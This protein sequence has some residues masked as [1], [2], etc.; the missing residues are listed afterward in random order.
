MKSG[1]TVIKGWAS[2]RRSSDR[3]GVA[4]ILVIGLLALMMVMGVSFAVFMRT[5]RMAA[6]NFRNDVVTRQLL[7]VALNQA[8]MAIDASMVTNVYP[9]FDVANSP[10]TASI[11]GATN[12]PAMSW[13]PASVVSASS[14][15]VDPKWIEVSGDGRVGYVVFN[16]SGLLDVNHVGGAARGIG[17]NVNEIQIGELP[18][19]G[20]SAG[21]TSL[22]TGHPYETGQELLVIGTNAGGG[23]ID[24]PQSLVTYSR[25]VSTNTMVDISADA[26]TLATNGPA[27]VAGLIRSGITNTQAPFVFTNLL[28]Y[29]DVGSIP[30]DL[31]SPCTEAVPMINELQ[32]SNILQFSS[33]KV[34]S[35]LAV[36]V[37]WVYPFVKINPA[38][39][40]LRCDV[41][42][43]G[44]GTDIKYVPSGTPVGTGTVFPSGYDGSSADM[45]MKHYFTTFNLTSS[46]TNCAPG[47]KIILKV[48]AGAQVLLGGVPV[49]SVPFPYASAG[50]FTFNTTNTV[51]APIP[52]SG[53]VGS[54]AQGAEVADPRFNW[55]TAS[56][57]VPKQWK[58]YSGGGSLG[59][60][61]SYTKAY[62]AAYPEY[63]ETQLSMHVSDQPLKSVSELSYLVRGALMYDKWST[64]KL[65]EDNRTSLPIDRVL[66]NFSI[67]TNTVYNGKLN[68]NS[69]NVAAITATLKGMPVD[70]YP[71][72]PASITLSSNQAANLATALTSLSGSFD[73]VSSFGKATNL[74]AIAPLAGLSFFQQESIFRNTCGLIHP[75]QNYFMILLIADSAKSVPLLPDK[76]AFSRVRA[77]AEVWRNPYSSDGTH[78]QT[79]VR[80]VR[81]LEEQ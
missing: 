32:V 44:V 14:V 31:G 63:A 39:F 70:E 3:S 30:G 10:G 64:I 42:V 13:I 58:Y 59:T 71:G 68:P 74:F 55:T 69:R 2:A 19:I 54:I 9:P 77:I 57:P 16:C 12:A 62:W 49:D 61:N 5:E 1:R 25:A 24:V 27:I 50:Y 76:V 29:V 52:A 79:I 20:S 8:L 6:G 23:L 73:A 56:T 28:D 36:N 48:Q 60:T 7:E 72:G 17:T 78:H 37:E 33:G 26:A 35:V 11:S 47:D 4:L 66:D 38:A 45:S 75:G 34:R 21:A 51:P 15:P 81:I 41:S 67:G 40:D 22:I 43:S 18:E 53:R 46:Y 80:L 65:C